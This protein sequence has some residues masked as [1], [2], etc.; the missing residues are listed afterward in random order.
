MVDKLT[1]VSPG[2]FL[3]PSRAAAEALYRD[4]VDGWVITTQNGIIDCVEEH[5]KAYREAVKE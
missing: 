1:E 3:T 4:L 2:V 5:L